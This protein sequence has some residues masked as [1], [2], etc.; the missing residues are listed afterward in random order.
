MT[1]S[2]LRSRCWCYVNQG[3]LRYC[4]HVR[5]INL[6]AFIGTDGNRFVCCFENNGQRRKLS[7]WHFDFCQFPNVWRGECYRVDV[8]FVFERAGKADVGFLLQRSHTSIQ[9]CCRI[10]RH[11]LA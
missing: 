9:V 10:D 3:R 1:N 4:L 8:D 6:L 2:F 11:I 5:G 7:G